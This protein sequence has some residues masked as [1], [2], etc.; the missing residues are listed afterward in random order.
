MPIRS[1]LATL[2]ATLAHVCQQARQHQPLLSKNEAATRAALIDPILLA[3]GW[4]TADVTMVEPEHTVQNK[5]SLDYVLKTCDGAVLAVIEA[6]RLGEP[7]DRLGH[8]GALI[9]YAFS[10]KP[11]VF[12]ITDG[13][14][15]HCYSPTHS[16]YEPVAT[17]HLTE[18][19]LLPTALQLLQLLD[20][21][22]GDHGLVTM[23]AVAS[24]AIPDFILPVPKSQPK[25]ASKKALAIVSSKNYFPLTTDLADPDKKL[26]KPHWLRLPD[27]EEHPLKTWKDILIKTAE[28]VLQSQDKLSIPLLDKAGKKT[29]LL[30]WHHSGKERSSQKIVYRGKTVFL[31]THYSARDCIANALYLLK[32]LPS[33]GYSTGTAIAFQ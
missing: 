26:G 13:L 33:K 18:A 16:H 21:A 1:P 8:V 12:F 4:D 3:L 10:L 23:P 29:V 30:D 28:L 24:E 19:T 5:Q 32:L 14:H 6:K 9:G 2:A 7:L 27:G 17:L 11:T 22:H 15:W 31:D 20:A 25:P